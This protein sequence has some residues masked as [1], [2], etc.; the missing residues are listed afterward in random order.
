MKALLSTAASR[1]WLG[2][3]LLGLILVALVAGLGLIGRLG[4][5]QHVADTAAPAFSDARV[6][7]TRAGVDELAA[8]V[9]LLDPLMTARGGGARDADKLMALMRRRM[10]LSAP[11]V[12]RILRREAPATRRLMRALPLDGVA[13]EI[14]RLTSFL[15]TRLTLSEDELAALLERDYPRV[16]EALTASRTLSGTW[17]AAPGVDGLTRLRGGAPVRSVPEIAAYFHDDVVP[18]VARRPAD[19]RGLAAR[20]GVG[21]LGPLAL[22]IG[23]G[24]L[25]FGLLMARRAQRVPAGA[26]AW[27]LV[28]AAGAL[29]A[30]VIGAA[31]L[32]PRLAGGERAATALAPALEPQRL[33]ATSAGADAL[34]EAVAF[35]APLMTADGGAARDA[36]G[37]YRFIAARTG[38]SVVDARR[39]VRHAAPR[40]AALLDA[41]PLTDVAREIPRLRA[42]LAR[43]LQMSAD[44][45]TATLRERAPAFERAIDAAPR[46]AAAWDAIGGDGMTR[47]DG[48]TPVRSAPQFDDYLRGDLV[49][50]LAAVGDDVDRLASPWP[51]LGAIAPALLALGLVVALYGAAMSLL[52]ARRR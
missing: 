37:L 46:A 22:A 50:A 20:G 35:G 21:Y 13:D 49:P 1:A 34:H 39:A 14:P 28:A 11:Q 40:T 29:L 30:L 19:V 2:V 45:L 4:A 23:L 3:A 7:G 32:L 48:V 9:A 12:R 51:P 42:Y 47:F 31:G 10:G 44:E 5:G 25:A 52:V 17:Y 6:A 8:Y 18:L 43:A 24:L 26:T 36:K 27:R 15:A 16:A 38:T 41:A 33:A